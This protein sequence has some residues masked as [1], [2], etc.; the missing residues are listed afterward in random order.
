MQKSRFS[1]NF[2]D[3]NGGGIAHRKEYDERRDCVSWGGDDFCGHAEIIAEKGMGEPHV[4]ALLSEGG[5]ASFEK[6]QS[7]YD[8]DAYER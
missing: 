7:A 8:V 3:K 5:Q 4:R 1:P 2:I 6:S